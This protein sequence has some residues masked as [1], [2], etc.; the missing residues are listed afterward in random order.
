MYLSI[1]RR[2]LLNISGLGVTI[3]MIGMGTHFLLIEKGIATFESLQWL[4]ISS[5]LLFSALFAIGIL[6]VPSTVLSETFPADIKCMVASIVSLTAAAFAFGATKSYQPLVDYYG[7]PF[8]LYL[9]AALTFLIV[10]FAMFCM[11]E[12]KGKTLQEIQDI[13]AKRQKVDK[14]RMVFKEEIQCRDN[15][16]YVSVWPYSL[17]IMNCTNFMIKTVKNVWL[18]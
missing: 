17:P 14:W 12:T 18:L 5:M 9:Y 15:I 8:V 4:I 1:P 11:I 13:L 6:A 2:I 3:S 7:H 16:L 10:P